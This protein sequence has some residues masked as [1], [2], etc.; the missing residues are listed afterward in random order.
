M[1]QHAGAW[2]LLRPIVVV[3]LF[4]VVLVVGYDYLKTGFLKLVGLFRG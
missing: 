1:K 2:F 3:I 4:L